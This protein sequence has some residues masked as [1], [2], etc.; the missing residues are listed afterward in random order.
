MYLEHS[1][2]GSFPKDSARPVPPTV[3]T[4]RFC[5]QTAASAHTFYTR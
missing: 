5:K 4:R 1:D 2:P 3:L